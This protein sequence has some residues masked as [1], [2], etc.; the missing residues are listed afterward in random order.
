M[1][2]PYDDDPGEIE[3]EPVHERHPRGGRK[4]TTGHK[5][6]AGRKSTRRR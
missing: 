4:K 2:D 5:K 1:S 6:T 3:T